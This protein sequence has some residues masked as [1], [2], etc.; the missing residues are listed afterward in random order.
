MGTMSRSVSTSTFDFSSSLLWITVLGTAGAA[1]F[2]GAVLAALLLSAVPAFITSIEALK[3]LPVFF[4]VG[5]ILLV[6]APNGLATL[7]RW[8]DFTTLAERHA[9]R[10][11]SRRLQERVTV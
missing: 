1:T 8:P 2:G 5:A 7:F 4:G 3:W 6:Q 10:V 9:W 11:G